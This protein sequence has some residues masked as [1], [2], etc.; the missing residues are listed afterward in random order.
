MKADAGSP[1]AS[2]QDRWRMRRLI[3]GAA[4]I[5]IGREGGDGDNDGDDDGDGVGVGVGVGDGMPEA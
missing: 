1:G 5:R 2:G 3:F 4:D